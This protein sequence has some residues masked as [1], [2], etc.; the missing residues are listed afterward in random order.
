LNLS[1]FTE[2]VSAGR[3]DEKGLDLFFFINLVISPILNKKLKS[4]ENK[5]NNK[6]KPNREKNRLNRLKF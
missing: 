5:K 1:R 3:L 2:Q 6:K 4:Q